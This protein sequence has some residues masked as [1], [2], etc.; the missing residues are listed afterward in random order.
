MK[1]LPFSA[2]T[3]AM[4][5]ALIPLLALFV[6]VSL[7]SGP[8]A[9][10]S[11]T[12]T[13]V[14]ERSISPGLF[15][16]GTV[17]ARYTY[18]IGPTGTGRLKNLEVEVGDQVAAG[19]IIGEIDPIDLDERIDAQEAAVKRAEAQEKEALTKLNYA[20]PLAIRY[21][22]LLA[23]SATS[24][25]ILAAKEHEQNLASAL[26]ATTRQELSRVQAELA[27]LKKQ[28][29]SL[30]LRAPVAGMVTLRH[31]EPGSTILAGQAVVEIIDP[32]SL[33][34]NVRFDQLH[35]HR[36]RAGLPAAITLRSQAGGSLGGRVLR[37]EPVADAVTEETL[38]KVAFDQVLQPSSAIGE[39]AE[40]IITLP[41]LAR[42]AVIPN[43]AIRRVGGK[44]GVWKLNDEGLQFAPLT[45][46]EADLD[47][48]VQVR[49]GLAV[50][51]R[52]VVYSTR[53]LHARSRIRIV[54][55][56]KGVKL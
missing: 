26:L 38:A 15:G 25:E 14:S 48:N 30:V 35:S 53:T 10:V 4:L 29:E 27:A 20:Q 36:L 6:Y 50:G 41:A 51:E 31:A 54:D 19:Q 46:G 16:I 17:A 2:R 5:V 28:R 1:R 7:R 49:E 39:L 55:D 23:A 42:Q 33:W 45:L 47:G 56:L 3:L 11:V 22:K 52:I 43:G 21:K 44:S 40:V 37:V 18:K 12:V 8:L 34:I 24:E 32:S 9:P 13:S